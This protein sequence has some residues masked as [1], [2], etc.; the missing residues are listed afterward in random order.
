MGASNVLDL[1]RNRENE[2]GDGLYGAGT[3]PGYAQQ[4]GP[5]RPVVAY[6]ATVWA[7]ET[8]DE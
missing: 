3:V 8:Q 7:F 4:V 5:E 6:G 2:R 1:R